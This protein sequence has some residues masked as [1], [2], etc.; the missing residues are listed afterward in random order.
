MKIGLRTADAVLAEALA[1]LAEERGDTLLRMREG[2]EPDLLCDRILVLCDGKVTGIVDGRT[3]TKEQ[4]GYLMTAD[5][6]VKGENEDH[7]Q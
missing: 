1:V 4:I 3:A 7:A 2:E 6:H 5:K